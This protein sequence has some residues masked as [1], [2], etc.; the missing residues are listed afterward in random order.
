MSYRALSYSKDVQFPHWR[1]MLQIVLSGEYTRSTEYKFEYEY[2]Q[3]Y[4][5]LGA[6]FKLF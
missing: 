4:Y 6:R 5:N 3:K 2:E 1:F